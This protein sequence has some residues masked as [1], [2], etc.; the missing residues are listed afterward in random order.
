MGGFR[1]PRDAVVGLGRGDCGVRSGR[2]DTPGR[3][4]LLARAFD[5]MAALLQA[6]DE[7]LVNV[8]ERLAGDEGRLACLLDECPVAIYTMGVTPDYVAT[9]ISSGGA[10]VLGH[11][12]HVF[13]ERP[14]LWL[15]SV[16][17]ED[18]ARVRGKIAELL[19][20]GYWQGEY[21]LQGADGSWRWIADE[22]RLVRSNAGEPQEIV[23]YCV[24]VTARKERDEAVACLIHCDDLTGLPNKALLE[25]RLVQALAQARRRD[26]AVA[27]LEFN[28]DGFSRLN[29][30]LGHRGA[31]SLL[32]ELARRLRAC[33]RAADTIA[34]RSGDNFVILIPDVTESLDVAVVARKLLDAAALPIDVFGREVHVTACIGVAMFPKDGAVA[35][36]LLANAANALARAKKEGRDRFHFYVESMNR[37][38]V[39]RLEIESALRHALERKELLLHYQPR[40]DL[41]SGRIVAAEALLRWQRNGNLVPPGEFIPL[42]EE[43][44]L[45]QPIGEW[46]LAEACR[47]QRDWLDRGIS[48]VTV[49]VNVSQQQL[50]ARSVGE[51]LPALCARHLA[52]TNLDNHWLELELTES[53]LMESPEQT[54]ALLRTLN[55]AG[56][57]L[58]ID[59]FGTGYSSLA[60][61]T[62]LPVHYLKI[63]RSFVKDVSTDPASAT[64]A[65]AIIG[66]AH[67]LHMTVIAEGVET[68]AQLRFLR[69]LGCDEIQGFLF[70]RPLPAQQ[71][72]AMLSAGKVI[73]FGDQDA[74]STLLLVD[75]EAA[76]LSA[77]KRTL[78]RDGYRIL[79]TTDPAEGLQLLALNHVQVVMSDQRMPQMSGTEFLHRVREL[80]PD[81]IRMVLSG[82][83][84]LQSITDAIN[85]GAI[86]RFLTKPWEDDALRQ[87]VREAFREYDKCNNQYQ[88]CGFRGDHAMTA[89]D[90]R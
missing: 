36:T 68:E 11:E 9:F 16:H 51:A 81:T 65:R 78:R 60:Y 74:S 77:L 50:R 37:G 25:D 39:D 89:R 84:D 18:C 66:L 3:P 15:D 75:D 32:L 53:L 20:A 35:D 72:E 57:K 48:I 71:F 90:G 76:I 83:A 47:Q 86:W 5:V 2:A 58:A 70:S 17:P 69:K 34:R 29:Q 88:D 61:L 52:A 38:A 7:S 30:T 63:D 33:L 46:V 80:H 62:Q 40:V 4:C 49:G 41:R 22:C 87:L 10:K 26:S 27:V 59:D 82:Y 45:I 23:G 67:N 44:G 54:I 12:P 79:T 6:C 31:D 43:T 85:K 64:V 21:R 1:S 73:A 28:L 55:D 14:S 8:T 13:I 19:A 24:D 42:A 56:T